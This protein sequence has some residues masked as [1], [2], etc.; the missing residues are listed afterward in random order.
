MQSLLV[1]AS[2]ASLY[3]VLVARIDSNSDFHSCLAT[4]HKESGLTQ[5][6]LADRIDS[7][8]Q[9]LKRYEAGSYQPTREVVRNL[10]SA[11]SVCSDQ[12]LFGKDECGPDDD[13]RLQLGTVSRGGERK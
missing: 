6:A 10:A 4:I 7:Q 12:L 3:P 9:Q 2:P 13:L 8:V 5:Q 11:L 1:N